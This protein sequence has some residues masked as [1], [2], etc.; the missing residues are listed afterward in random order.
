MF[1]ELPDGMDIILHADKVILKRPIDIGVAEVVVEVIES[2]KTDKNSGYR[3]YS[4]QAKEKN[5]TIQEFCDS[6]GII[7]GIFTKE[8]DPNKLMVGVITD[9]YCSRFPVI[10]ATMSSDYNNHID[11]PGE[12]IRGKN[13]DGPPDATAIKYWNHILN[14]SHIATKNVVKG[15]TAIDA[16]SENVYTMITSELTKV[17]AKSKA[18]P[19]K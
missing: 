12:S 16:A 13:M 4:I 11:T 3:K 2:I 5:S 1:V 18:D 14:E 10:V 8:K 6:V 7:E 17:R 19:D 15:F 9:A